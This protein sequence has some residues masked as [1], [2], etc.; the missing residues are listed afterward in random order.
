MILVLAAL[1]LIFMAIV[2]YLLCKLNRKSSSASNSNTEPSAYAVL[3]VVEPNNRNTTASST[4]SFAHSVH[5]EVQQQE[6]TKEI[7]CL[8]IEA[9]GSNELAVI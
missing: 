4:S 1:L 6:G 5:K 9:V 8:E 2:L 7:G 3:G